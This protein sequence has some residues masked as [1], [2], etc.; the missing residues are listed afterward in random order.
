MGRPVAIAIVGPDSVGVLVGDTARIGVRVVDALGRSIT[1]ATFTLTSSDDGVAAPVSGGGVVARGLGAAVVTAHTVSAAGAPLEA[2]V[3]VGVVPQFVQLASGGAHG[4][5]ITGTA[6]LFCW[7]S[8][9]YGQLGLGRRSPAACGADRFRCVSVPVGVELPSSAGAVVTVTAGAWH[10]CALTADGTAFCWGSNASG[11]LET[12]STAAPSRDPL[13]VAGGWHFVSLAAGRMHTCGLTE[14]GDA[15]CWGNDR[16][17]QLGGGVVAPDRCTDE[18]SFAASCARL[19]M[20]VAGGHQFVAIEAS[21]KITC[22]RTAAGAVWCWGSY[23][24]IPVEHLCHD[25]DQTG[26]VRAPFEVPG[27]AGYGQLT[28]GPDHQCATRGDR[29]LVCWGVNV[30]GAFGTGPTSINAVAAAPVV[31]GGGRAFAS[32]TAGWSYTCAI[33][34]DGAAWCWGSNYL[35]ALGIGD[36]GIRDQ[37]APARVAGGLRFVRL[38]AASSS[39]TT[40][41][42]IATD[43]RAYCWGMGWLG[44]RGDGTVLDVQPTPARVALPR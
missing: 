23:T 9:D 31:A 10:T 6:R 17:S 7:G 13:P 20:R 32:V 34:L 44:G 3:R 25:G 22:G 11:Q 16:F 35:G 41:C 33:D 18:F 19:P 4:C 42:G 12:G 39:G 2:R 37:P 15:F 28:V 40:T 38:T 21:E 43:G 30:A 24:S 1:D 14:A 27:S 36:A 26:C 5:G 29:T 8:D